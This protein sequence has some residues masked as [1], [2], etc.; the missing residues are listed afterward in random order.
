ML[1]QTTIPEITP[2]EASAHTDREVLLDVR[3]VDEWAAGHAP[4]SV[5]LPLSRLHPDRLPEASRLLCVCR[6]GAR[7]GRVVAALR[8]AGYEAVNVAGGMNAWQAD[9]LAVVRADDRPGTV[10]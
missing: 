8:N 7:S 4:G 2:V 5:N 10:I 3:E 6:S 1:D 9:G